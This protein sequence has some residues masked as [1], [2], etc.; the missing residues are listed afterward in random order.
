M[1]IGWIYSPVNK[2]AAGLVTAALTVTMSRKVEI[3]K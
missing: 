2:E 1:T 3:E